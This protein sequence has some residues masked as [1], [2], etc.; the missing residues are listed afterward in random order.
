MR[1]EFF[2]MTFAVNT[3]KARSNT[4]FIIL[5]LLHLS[6]SA[7]GCNLFLRCLIRIRKKTWKL[8][9]QP[10]AFDHE[11][12]FWNDSFSQ[13]SAAE[14]YWSPTRWCVCKPQNFENSVSYHKP[15]QPLPFDLAAINWFK[16]LIVT[17]VLG[18]VIKLTK[19]LRKQVI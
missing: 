1:I 14:R 4:W 11:S 16:T 19:T 10:L 15:V 12:D 5:L 3:M 17:F 6:T 7:G 8:Q 18:G 13:V 2:F 9:S